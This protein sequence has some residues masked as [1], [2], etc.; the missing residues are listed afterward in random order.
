MDKIVICSGVMLA[1]EGDLL[2][3]RKK[4]S[5]YFQLPGGKV[6]P[7]ESREETL[8]RELKEE[9][10]YDVGG[11]EIRFIGSHST[12][13]VNELNTV[14]V[15]YIYLIKLAERHA[16]EAYEELDEVLW[17]S[18]ANWQNYRWAHLASEFVLPKWLSGNF[19]Q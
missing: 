16:F 8:I 10:Q 5:S 14:V 9:L 18:K 6:A 15:G 11:M 7:E 1:P 3:V 2:M 4:G 19:D 17:I 13:A 12:Q